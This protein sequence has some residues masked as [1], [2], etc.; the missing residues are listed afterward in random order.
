MEILVT[1]HYFHV[2]YKNFYSRNP[3]KEII[4]EKVFEVKGEKFSKDTI[5]NIYD[6]MNERSLLSWEA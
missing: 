5:S 1:V 6:I 4:I 3:E 2:S